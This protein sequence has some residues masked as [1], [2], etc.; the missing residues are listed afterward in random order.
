MG[1]EILSE[2]LAGLRPRTDISLAVVMMFL[3]K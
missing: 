3:P 2:L 1:G